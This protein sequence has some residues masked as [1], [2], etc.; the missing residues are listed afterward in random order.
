[1]TTLHLLTGNA[2]DAKPLDNPGTD[3]KVATAGAT[4]APW[5]TANGWQFIRYPEAKF[6]SNASGPALPLAMIEAFA[7][8]GQVWFTVSE[9]DQ[10]IWDKTLAFLESVPEFATQRRSQ[11]GV[12]EDGSDEM[13]EV[14]KLLARRNLMAAPLRENVSAEVV[15]KLGTPEYSR[16]SARNPAQFAARVRNQLGDDRRLIR[17][18][19]SDVLLCDL[20]GN[21]GH[22]RVHLTNYSNRE[23]HGAR[24]RVLGK[25]PNVKLMAFEQLDLALQD[26]AMTEGGTEFTVPLLNRYAVIDLT[27]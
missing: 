8:R 12:Q 15:V 4:A 6:V 5:V 27:S 1:M 26:V 21:G 7:W 9:A 20:E 24:V 10:P 16:E 2:P 14:L 23:I 3:Y 17:I 25:F 11:I 19:G 18:Y 13:G 22:S